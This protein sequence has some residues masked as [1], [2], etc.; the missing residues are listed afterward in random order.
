MNKDFLYSKYRTH[1]PGPTGRVDKLGNIIEFRLTFEEWCSIWEESG[2]RPAY[3]WV[4]SRRND[5]G[6]YEMG[7]VYVQHTSHNAME[8]HIEGYQDNEYEKSITELSIKTGYKRAC[9]KKMLKQGKLK[10]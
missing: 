1:P 6:H 4:L 2:K 5:I 8:V 3:P 10:L 9:V 7:N